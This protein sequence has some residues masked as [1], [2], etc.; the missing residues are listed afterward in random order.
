MAGTTIEFYSHIREWKEFSNF[1]PSPI[2]YDGRQYPTVEHL[3]QAMKF[4]DTANG[5]QYAEAIR[6]VA[7]PADAKALG[8]QRSSTARLRN[9]IDMYPG[10]RLRPD[11]EE[12]KDRIMMDCLRLKFQ[13]PTL[14]V[15]L[16]STGDATLVEHTAKDSYWADGGN[17]RGLNRLGQLLMQ[18]RGEIRATVAV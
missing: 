6:R 2:T 12:Q 3:F 1:F 9:I 15:V 5:R 11:W 7:T 17:G 4:M 8:R 16:L 13:I 10:V 14:R 18:L